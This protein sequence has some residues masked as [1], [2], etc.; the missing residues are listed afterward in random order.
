MRGI[1]IDLGTSNTL[2]AQVGKSDTFSFSSFVTIDMEE[3]MI[4][5]A[6]N[7]SK[8]AFGKTPENI[9]AKKPLSGG[10][11]AD[12]SAAEGMVKTLVKE[13]F[14]RAVFTG[15]NAI[16]TVPSSATQMERRA[17]SEVVKNLGVSSV[18]VI[19][20]AMASA[21][22]AGINVLT[23]TGSMIV[24]IGGGTTDSAVIALGHIA[25]GVSIK[26]GGDDMD[27]AV[28]ALVKRKFNVLI[29]ENTA[30]RIK[31]ELGCALPKEKNELKK[32]KGRDIVTGLPKE[33]SVTS[34]EVREAISDSLNHIVESVILALEKTPSE[35]LSDVMETGIT[36]TGGLAGLYKI[37][38]L[39]T[40]KT[41]FKTKVGENPLG[42]ALRGEVKI[43]SDKKLKALGK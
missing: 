29:G 40:K 26:T 18:K 39:L 15:V 6:G 27:S 13:A 36:I 8:E 24:D 5:D 28:M 19:E 12:Y 2:M 34:E 31:I 14:N 10:V 9:I 41:G 32:Y 1:C 3:S 16:I 42:C 4:I 20:G 33:F 35:L 21:V 30:E 25:T 17:A 38:E 11:I 22:G 37:D 23:P 43:L 7:N